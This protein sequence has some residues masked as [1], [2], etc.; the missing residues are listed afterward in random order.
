MGR[1]TGTRLDVSTTCLNAPLERTRSRLVHTCLRYFALILTILGIVG[2]AAGQT[3]VVTSGGSAVNQGQTLPINTIPNMPN[4]VLSVNGGTSCDTFSFQVD[5]SYTDQA[6]RQTGATYEADDNPGGNAVTVD[7]NGRLEGGVATITWTFDGVQQSTFG[8]FI[9]GNNPAPSAVDAYASSGPWFIRNMI[10]DESSY[11]QFVSGY[12]HFGPDRNPTAGGIGLFQL[13][14]PSGD[15][16]YWAWY[17]NVADG[18]SLLNGKQIGAYNHW[19]TQI[20]NAQ[21]DGGP[22]PPSTYGTYCAF[23]Y[24]PN[25]GDYYGDADWIHA[26]NSYYYT[27][28]VRPSGGNPGHWNMDGYNGSGYVQKV[29]NAVPQ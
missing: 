17:T 22:N 12:P 24:P 11:L 28:W 13:D 14:P 27:L 23:Q 2:V 15:E 19:N 7:W 3:L 8:F 26:Y 20:T 4:L 18:L 6:G 10:T 9:I 1:F 5:V 21:A 29:C 25:G 16:D